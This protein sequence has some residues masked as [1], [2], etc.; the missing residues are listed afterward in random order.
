VQANPGTDAGV[1]RLALAINSGLRQGKEGKEDKDPCQ[2]MYSAFTVI[3]GSLQGHP[4]AISMLLRLDP[5]LVWG[6]GFRLV[7]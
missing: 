7:R 1:F 3:E 2:W 6:L 5:P 4:L